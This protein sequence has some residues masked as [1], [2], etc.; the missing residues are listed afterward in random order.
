MG[1][2]LIRLSS[3]GYL[4]NFSFFKYLMATPILCS[5]ITEAQDH[6]LGRF[7]VLSHWSIIIFPEGTLE[8]Y[9][10]GVPV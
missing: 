5:R 8:T 6:F 7:S 4:Y 3:C 10:M 2:N 9:R 1:I